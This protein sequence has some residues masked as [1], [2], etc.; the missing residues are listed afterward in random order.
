MCDDACC[1]DFLAKRIQNSYRTS[2]GASGTIK[3]K[4]RTIMKVLLVTI[5]IGEQHFAECTNLFYESQHR[6]ATKHGSVIDV[7]V[8]LDIECHVVDS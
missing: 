6:Y 7:F 3:Y 5:A 1:V 8:H 4:G 2:T